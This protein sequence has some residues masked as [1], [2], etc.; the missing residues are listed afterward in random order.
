[1]SDLRQ[2]VI[3]GIKD[4]ETPASAVFCL[5][6]SSNTVSVGLDLE[7]EFAEQSNAGIVGL[8][9]FESKLGPRM[10]LDI[11]SQN[12]VKYVAG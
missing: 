2:C 9:F 5:E 6:G 11:S 12:W 8:E 10:D 4:C 3:F 1:M 7:S